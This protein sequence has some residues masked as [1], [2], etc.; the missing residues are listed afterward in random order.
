MNAHLLTEVALSSPNMHLRPQLKTY[1]IAEP[2]CW[3][4]ARDTSS[5]KDSLQILIGN[6]NSHT[7]SMGTV[8]FPRTFTWGTGFK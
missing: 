6:S 1:Q 7:C 3:P 4:H 8:L 2:S 5:F